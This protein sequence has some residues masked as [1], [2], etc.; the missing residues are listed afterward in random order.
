[1]Q[2]ELG[3]FVIVGALTVLV[4][5]ATYRALGWTGMFGVDVAK[6]ASFLVGTA[7]AYVANRHWTFGH[8]HHV[9]HSVWRFVFLYLM[10]LAVNVIVNSVV[11][12]LSA[13]SAAASHIAF[14]CATGTSATLNFLGMKFFVFSVAPIREGE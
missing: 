12:Q 14:I 2:R 11:L 7:F 4:D 6:G 8:Y 5:F 13:S 10:T 3:V 1:M 9:R